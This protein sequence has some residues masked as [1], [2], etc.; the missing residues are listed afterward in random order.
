MTISLSSLA[1]QNE[2][3]K[4]SSALI[5]DGLRKKKKPLTYQ[6]KTNNPDP[7]RNT[8]STHLFPIIKKT[9]QSKQRPRHSSELCSI[10]DIRKRERPPSLA[11]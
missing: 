11:G 8:T 7:A 6:I 10:A 2:Q 9:V 4:P 3:S 1:D 5:N